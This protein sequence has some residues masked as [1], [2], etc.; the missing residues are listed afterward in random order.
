M[1]VLLVHN[2]YQIAGGE[3]SMFRAEQAVL[4]QHGIDV[5]LFTVTNDSIKGPVSQVMA[6][7][8]VI[9][10][11]LA[12]RALARK[13][14]ELAPDVVHVHNFFPQ[15]S[16]AIFDACR[17]ARIPSVLTLHNFRI[18]C[19]T[20]FLGADD[21]DRER[22]LRQSCWWTVPRKVYRNSAAATLAVAGMVEFHK[23]A[24]TWLHKVD[25]FIALTD[26]A[27]QIFTQG[28]LPAG[29]ISVKPNWVT[30]PAPLSADN[31]QKGALFVGRL[32]EQKGVRVLLQAW[33]GLDYPLTIIG[34]G[35][36]ADLVKQSASPQITF[37]GRQPRERVQQEM[38]RARFLVL[39]SVGYEMFPLTVLE[40][41]AN[42]LPVLCSDLPSLGGLIEHGVTGLKFPPNDAA[43]LSDRVRQA[44]AEPAMLHSMGRRAERLYD[45]CYTPEANVRQLME[46]YGTARAVARNQA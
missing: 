32:D 27:K 26:W 29:R 23:W 41:F 30:R 24:G 33:Q 2:F 5:S 9:Y 16:P 45:T 20:A 14:A 36:L 42:H 43:A 22:S 15:L 44:V 13:L 17:D 8:Q 35:P 18:L 11:P 37:L 6:G 1:R 3:D 19:P 40:A 21:S 34:D 39:P 7:L 31:E 38:Q 25:Q 46:I 10:N 4:K 28:G 12:R